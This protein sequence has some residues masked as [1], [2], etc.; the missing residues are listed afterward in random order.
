[1]RYRVRIT[2]Y[3]LLLRANRLQELLVED[4][5]QSVVGAYLHES[6]QKAIKSVRILPEVRSFHRRFV[7]TGSRQPPTM[8]S[9]RRD[10]FSHKPSVAT[11]QP[12]SSNR[13]Q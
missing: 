2:V 10:R 1:M 9:P 11:I 13:R 6:F 3:H 5:S 8:L 4:L 7:R 12:T